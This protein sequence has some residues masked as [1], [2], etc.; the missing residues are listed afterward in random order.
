MKAR[1]ANSIAVQG[2]SEAGGTISSEIEVR[3]PLFGVI[4]QFG[5][6]E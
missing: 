1:S 3:M 4:I 5:F 6:I 2:F